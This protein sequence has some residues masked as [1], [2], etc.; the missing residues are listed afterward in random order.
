MTSSGLSPISYSDQAEIDVE[1]FS[2]LTF[3]MSFETAQFRKHLVKFY[4]DTYLLP[5]PSAVAGIVGAVLGVRRPE[6]AIKGKTLELKTG[7]MMLGYEGLISETMTVIKMK[8][9][10]EA[11]RT[12][13]RNVMLFR[14]SYKLAIASSN[15]EMIGEL[16]DRLRKMR[17][18]FDPFGGNDYNFLSYIGD[19]R[20]AKLVRTDRG[21]GCSRLSEL[22][23]IE[24]SGLVQV[25]E[26]NDGNVTKYAFGYRVSF[27]VREGLAVDDG[28]HQILVHDA[29]S[30]LR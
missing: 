28:E 29:H 11:I 2:A 4:R 9:W 17:F 3:R 20:E 26:V 21:Y 22:R 14:P 19:V 30:F 6:L 24:G 18:E 5:L 15:D 12:P 16:A 23:G 13:K 7:S 8:G 1:R 25:D 10:R 27:L